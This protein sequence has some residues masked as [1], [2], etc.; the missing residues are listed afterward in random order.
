MGHLK[1]TKFLL[2]I[3]V[4]ILSFSIAGSAQKVQRNTQ[5]TPA[6]TDLSQWVRH[7]RI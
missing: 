5:S 2:L 6:S 7:I 3:L 4:S 1:K